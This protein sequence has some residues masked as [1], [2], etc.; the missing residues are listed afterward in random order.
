MAQFTNVLIHT[1]PRFYADGNINTDGTWWLNVR[2][3]GSSVSAGAQFGPGLTM[4]IYAVY[5]DGT[6]E[7]VALMGAEAGVWRDIYGESWEFSGTLKNSAGKTTVQFHMFCDSW[8]VIGSHCEVLNGDDTRPGYGFGEVYSLYKAPSGFSV[9]VSSNTST[10]MT[11]KASW[12]NGSKTSTATIKVGDKTGTISTNGGTTEI[13]GLTPNT[14]Y[15][16]SGSLSDGTTTLTASTTKYTN[17]TAPSSWTTA[18]STTN[19]VTLGV[20]S[21]NNTTGLYYQY[22]LNGGTWQNS[23]TF[24]NLTPNTLYTVKA[25]A[26]NDS[27]T[28]LSTSGELSGSIW[29]VPSISSLTVSLKSGAEHD[30]INATV[31]PVVDSGNDSYQ[32]RIGTTSNAYVKSFNASWSGLSGNT[33]YTIGVKLKNNTSG[34]ESAEVTKDIT[35]WYDPISNLKINM[36]NRWFW[37]LAVNSSYTYGGTISKFEF[38]IGS[39]QS[40]Q[41]KGTTNSHSRGSTTGGTSGNLAYNTD[42]LCKVRLTDNHGRTAEAQATFKTLDERPLYI[43][44]ALREV[45]LIKSDGSVV[46]I[47]PNLL[48]VVQENGTVTNMNKIINNDD[49][50]SF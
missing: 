1:L 12:T 20:S 19:S 50:K 35:T 27:N 46:Y 22:Q 13:T 17:L 30:A 18:S 25:R 8:E 34:K 7:T 32:F 49:R 2:A 44:G 3:T 47:T 16:I 43:N 45:K 15:T 5:N 26:K 36:T 41:N 29:T 42:Y 28:S 6:Y 40:Y 37:Y 31:S 23:G 4:T 9:S 11:V 14:N 10:N 24:N 21:N 39:D 48:S 33:T 38:S